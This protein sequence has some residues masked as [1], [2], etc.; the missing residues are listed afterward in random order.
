M[1]ERSKKKLTDLVLLKDLIPRGELKGGSTG[2]TVFGE[3]PPF[4]EPGTRE[5]QASLK[6]AYGN[7][8]VSIYKVV[9]GKG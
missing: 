5:P 4:S 6:C 1:A 3:V 8:T 9:E 2:K 7:A